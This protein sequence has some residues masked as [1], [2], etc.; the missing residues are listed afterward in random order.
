PPADVR[1]AKAQLAQTML[2]AVDHFTTE[3][4]FQHKSGAVVPV[5][6]R[7]YIQ[8]DRNGQPLRISGTSMDLTE[9]K[10][11]EQMKDQFVSTVSH[12]LRTP[13]T[14]ISGALGLVNGGALG[15]VPGSMR[16]T[17][18]I[19]HRNSLRLGYL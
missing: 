8:R 6:I 18:E 15:E 4:R 17:L 2:S 5:L 11:I 19:A 12:E 13:L 9:H 7:G 3:L 14:S 1:Q 16:E 10:R